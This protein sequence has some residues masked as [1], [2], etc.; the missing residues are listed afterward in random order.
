MLLRSN[1]PMI[2]LALKAG[3]ATAGSDFV[4]DTGAHYNVIGFG[5]F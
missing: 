2:H 3:R 5:P 1:T 4:F